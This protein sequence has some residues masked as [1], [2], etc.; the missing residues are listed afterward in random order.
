MIC[1]IAVVALLTEEISQFIEAAIE[2]AVAAAAG[3]G[4][5]SG[6]RAHSGDTRIHA[7][8]RIGSG[9]LCPILE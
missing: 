4:D 3:L 9:A 1:G 8:I 5:R 6:W 2:T 7:G